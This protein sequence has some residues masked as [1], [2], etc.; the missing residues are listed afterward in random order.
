[1][2]IANM[3]TMP[4]DQRPPADPSALRIGTPWITT[5]G[6]KESEM[7]Q[8]AKWMDEVMKIVQPWADLKF[9][10]FEDNVK[11]SRKIN[12]IANEVELLCKKFALDIR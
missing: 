7:N 4:Q 5:R 12:T 1:G 3:N 9:E 10:E 8:I 2:I 6:M 11:D